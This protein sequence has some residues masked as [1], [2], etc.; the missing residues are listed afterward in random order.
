[1]RYGARDPAHSVAVAVGSLLQ[2]VAEVAQQVPSIRDLL[3]F[4]SPLTKSAW[5]DSL[6]A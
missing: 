4:S 3:G 6:S 5:V 1:V 2:G